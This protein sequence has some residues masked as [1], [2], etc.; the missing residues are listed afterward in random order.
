MHSSA[1]AEYFTALLSILFHRGPFA[2]LEL[3]KQIIVQYILLYYPLCVSIM[4]KCFVIREEK[5][6]EKHLLLIMIAHMNIF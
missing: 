4:Y 1:D 3:E 2:F 6:R 5:D